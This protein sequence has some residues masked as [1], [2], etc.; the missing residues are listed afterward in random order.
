MKVEFLSKFNK[1]LEKLDVDHVRN[2]VLKSIRFVETAKHFS[3]IPHIKKLKG[4]K[5]AYRIKIGDYR[6]GLFIEGNVAEFARIHHRKDIYT[7][8]P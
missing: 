5:S 8:F 1:D 6:I 7:F 4:H 3:E 2:A